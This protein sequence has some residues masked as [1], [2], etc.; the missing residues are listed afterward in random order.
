MKSDWECLERA[1]RGDETAWRELIARHQSALL[2]TVLLI[3][4]SLPSAHDLAQETFVRLLRRRP[5]HRRGSFRAY[6]STIA[7]RLAL[8]ELKRTRRQANL[9]NLDLPDQKPDPLAA[10]LREERDRQL[11]AVIGELPEHHR[12]ILVLR[13]YG[14]HSYDEIAQIT[15][16]P[17]GTVKSRIFNAVKAC[18]A[19][20]YEK[21]ILP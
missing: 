8:K 19:G 4:G 15:A 14:R 16:L 17:L 9:D 20:M 11:A 2:R 3:T 1:R 10:I 6:L 13:F 21:G 18:R 12:T 7:Y 5:R